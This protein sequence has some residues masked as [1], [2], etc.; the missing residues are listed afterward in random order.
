MPQ[1][2]SPD[3]RSAVTECRFVLSSPSGLTAIIDSHGARLV[4]LIAPDR[5]GRFADVVL[6]YDCAEDYIANA[7]MYFGATVGRVAQRI[8][9]ATFSLDGHEYALATNNGRN[10]LHGGAERSFDKVVWGASSRTT[11]EGPEVEF[12]HTSPHLEEG[13][14]GNVDA[15]VTYRLTPDGEVHITYRATT[16]RAT[17]V[18]MTNHAYW[19][20]AGAGAATILD[21][22]L[23]VRA[24]RYTVTDEDL[25]PTGEIR[26]VEGT[27]LDLQAP[28]I[29]ADRIA[30]LEA[31]GGFDHNLVLA[32]DRPSGTADA[33]LRHPGTGRVLEIRST[34]PCIQVYSGNLMRPSTGKLGVG[35]GIRSAIC[36]EP[37]SWPDALHNPNFPSVILQPNESYHETATYRLLTDRA[38]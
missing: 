9:G 35:Y 4:G 28:A 3:H 21:H 7:D 25:I 20:L 23:S 5:D 33:T 14:P 2:R 10:S 12:R 19:N 16:D 36:L 29:L 24:D 13:Y 32:A 30:D 38:R 11:D 8:K 34:L 6:G 27:P 1:H 26:P 15:S 22:E 17:P 31:T 37:Q 18:S